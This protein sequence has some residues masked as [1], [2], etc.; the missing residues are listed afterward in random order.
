MIYRF[1]N[2]FKCFQKN[3]ASLN[4][5]KLKFSYK[6]DFLTTFSAFK[7]TLKVIESCIR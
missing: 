6:S 7:K 4:L 1:I 2:T 3:R 5:N